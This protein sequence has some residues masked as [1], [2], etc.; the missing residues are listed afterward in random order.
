MLKNLSSLLLSCI[1]LTLFVS[2]SGC[3]TQNELRELREESRKDSVTTRSM[4]TG[5]VDQAN[6]QLDTQ[7]TAFVD[8]QRGLDELKT[9]VTAV[10]GIQAKL[11]E[12][13]QLQTA[14]QKTLEALKKQL[15]PL[16][17]IQASLNKERTAQQGVV[18]E[19]LLKVL[20]T[21]QVELLHRAQHLDEAMKELEQAGQ[22]LGSRPA[23]KPLPNDTSAE[24]P[25]K[26]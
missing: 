5:R 14:Q 17:E 18:R 16:A 12:I 3:A 7:K 8:Q 11:E 4:L 23:D 2:T 10:T 20:K 22:S 26:R 6:R 1:L 13:Q 21:E 9:Q 24:S 25:V 15:T 19:T